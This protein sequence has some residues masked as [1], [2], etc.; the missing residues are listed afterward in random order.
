M[1][2][3]LMD[4]QRGPRSILGRHRCDRAVHAVPS[5]MA[6]TSQLIRE[7]SAI[8]YRCWENDRNLFADQCA[9]RVNGS[10]A[11]RQ[12]CPRFEHGMKERGGTRV[13]TG[14]SGGGLGWDVR[15]M[16]GKSSPAGPSGARRAAPT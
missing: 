16:F 10:L 3:V 14:L 12:A 13:R 15:P 5:V 7:F 4:P 9:S 2:T 11:Q 8:L 1:N 6:D